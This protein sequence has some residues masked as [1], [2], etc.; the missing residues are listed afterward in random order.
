MKKRGWS[1]DISKNLE[2][3]FL[4]VWF[5]GIFSWWGDIFFME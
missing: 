3:E 2:R 4:K 5:K 1:M